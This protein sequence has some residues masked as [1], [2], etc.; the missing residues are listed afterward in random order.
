MR[1]LVKL[2]QVLPAHLSRRVSALGSA[3]VRP[4]AGGPTVDPHHLTV[5]AAACRD[6]ECL[7]FAYRRRDGIETRREVEPHA[8]VNLGRR[9]YLA[10]WDRGREDWRIVPRRPSEPAGLDRHSLHGARAARGGRRRLRR[11]EHPGIAAPLR[12]PRH[13]ARRSRRARGPPAEPLGHGRADRRPHLRVPDRRR[14]PELARPP[15]NDAAGRLR[16]AR[17]AGAGG[18]PG[19]DRRPAE[20]RDEWRKRRLAVLA[21]HLAHRG[22]DAGALLLHGLDVQAGP[23]E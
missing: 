4:P 19:G 12:G 22:L 14:R 7:R 13:P 8:L 10:A 23:L 11:T 5:I 17:A 6:S 15:R 16:G 1:A 2:E 20:P 18:A 9:W 21:R 3:M